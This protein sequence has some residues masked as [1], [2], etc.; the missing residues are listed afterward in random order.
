MKR[1]EILPH[2]ADVRLKVSAASLEELINAALEGMNKI[3]SNEFPKE[4]FIGC[5][6]E[7]IEVSSLDESMLLIDFLSEVLTMTHKNKCI[8]SVKKLYELSNTK[9]KAVLNGF[10]V[11]GFDEDIKAVTYTEAKVTK[12]TDG[13]LE[14][15]IV[16]DI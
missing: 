2:T 1:F 12:S 9:I 6:E 4:D 15:I 11:N 14:I 10:K 7:I 13:L 5:K 16:F 3:I 8:F